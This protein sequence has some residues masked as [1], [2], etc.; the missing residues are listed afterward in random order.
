MAG[1]ELTGYERGNVDFWLNAIIG[2]SLE[3]REGFENYVVVMKD[4]RIVEAGET[5]ALFASPQ[6]AYTRALLTAVA[7]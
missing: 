4:G 7:Q 5:E 2:P 1:P 6:Q 3:I